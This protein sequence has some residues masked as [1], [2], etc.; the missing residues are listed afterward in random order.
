TRRDSDSAGKDSGTF[1][2]SKCLRDQDNRNPKKAAPA[3]GARVAQ[4]RSRGPRHDGLHVFRSSLPDEH[5]PVP[6]WKASSK[7][8]ERTIHA[9]EAAETQKRP[10]RSEKNSTWE[11]LALNS[12][13]AFRGP[14]KP[15]VPLD[16]P[17]DGFW[18]HHT[19][20]T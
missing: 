20:W 8:P 13:L 10:A 19:P 18:R 6:H 15:L 17:V 5:V 9:E 12:A 1:I 7:Q 3:P 4:P 2:F 14:R 16:S 11:S